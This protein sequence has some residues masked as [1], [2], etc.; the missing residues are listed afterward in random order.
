LEKNFVRIGQGER[1]RRVA[2]WSAGFLLIPVGLLTPV[3]FFHTGAWVPRAFT[4]AAQLNFRLNEYDS[5]AQ[6]TRSKPW[7]K[8]FTPSR[9]CFFTVTPLANDFDDL[10]FLADVEVTVIDPG[11]MQKLGSIK[12]DRNGLRLMEIS[13]DGQYLV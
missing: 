7:L 1:V 6:S 8:G 11:T 2:Q 3:L 4:P 10:G 12:R 5:S 9:R 13:P